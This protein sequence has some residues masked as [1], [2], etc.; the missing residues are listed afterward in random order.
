MARVSLRTGVFTGLI[1]ACTPVVGQE[2]IVV[3][4]D[5]STRPEG[6]PVVTQMVRDSS[7]YKDALRGVEQP[8]PY[9]LRFLEDQGN[10]FNPFQQPGMTGPY[11][12]RGLH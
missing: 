4:N 2:V 10:W 9:S 8:Y 7:W 6:A 12:I 11:D 1:F 5:P 3:G